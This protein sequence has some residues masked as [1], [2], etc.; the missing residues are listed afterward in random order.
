[1]QKSLEFHFFTFYKN[2]LVRFYEAKPET[3]V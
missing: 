2:P 3:Q 1:M